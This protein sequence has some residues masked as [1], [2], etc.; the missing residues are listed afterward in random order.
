MQGA[1]ALVDEHETP[2]LTNAR[3]RIKEIADDLEDIRLRCTRKTEKNG[4]IK[5]RK[6]KWVLLKKDLSELRSKALNAKGDLL[7]AVQF[8]SLK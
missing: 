3:A 6:T 4:K 5:P 2:Q 8:L 7:L 1:A